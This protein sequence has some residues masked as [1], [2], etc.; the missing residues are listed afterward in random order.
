MFANAVN[1][2]VSPTAGQWDPGQTGKRGM[3][4]YWCFI[5]EREWVNDEKEEEL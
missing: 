2:S 5:R 4:L 3:V 1:K